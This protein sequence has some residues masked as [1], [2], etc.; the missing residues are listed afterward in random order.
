M[1]AE[2]LDVVI[3]ALQAAGCSP[4]GSSARCPAHDDHDP[5]LSFGVGDD[6]RVL[7]RCHAGCPVEAIV[8]ALELT[9]TDLF[10]PKAQADPILATYV[11]TDES[12]VPLF[13]V[14]RKSP[15]RFYQQHPDCNG[16]WCRTRGNARL[17]LY[18]LPE[19]LAG[20]AAGKTVFVCEGEKDAEAIVRTGRVA[21]T[22][23][24][25]AGKWRAEYVEM[26]A[27]AKGVVIVADRD[28]VGRAHASQVADSL[29]GRVGRVLIAEP[30]EGK[31]L[32]DHLTIGFDVEDLVTTFDSCGSA[33]PAL[34][35]QDATWP[36]LDDAALLG[37]PGQVVELLSPHSEAD[38]VALL[39]NFLAGF[40]NAAGLRPHVVADGNRNRANLDVLVIGKTAKSR[41]GTAWARVRSLLVAATATSDLAWASGRIVSGLSSGEGLINAV[42][43]EV[44]DRKGILV[45]AARDKRLLVVEE[46]FSRVLTVKGRENNPLSAIMRQAW[47]GTDLHVLTKNPLTAKAPHISIVG[48]ITLAELRAQLTE[49]DQLNGF[50]NRFLCV[51]VRRSK[52]LPNG[53]DPTQAASSRLT[54]LV[55]D[56]LGV[57]REK[58]R[59]FRNRDAE[60]RWSDLYS[61]MACDDE[62]GMVG[63]AAARA[64]AHVTRLSLVYALACGA[65]SIE[66]D[67]LEAAWALWRYCRQSLDYV[68]GSKLG[69]EVVDRLLDALRVAALGGLD[70][71]EQFAVFGRNISAGRLDA[72][73]DT[74]VRL[75][76][77]EVVPEQTG[78]RPRQVLR[79][80]A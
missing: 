30:K 72:A 55:R 11:Y 14:V 44:R 38:P 69:D 42:C 56:R 1:T 77:A 66:L 6:G 4:K 74:L 57:A 49:T 3:A 61:E 10:V 80:L 47:D 37:L 29:I 31:D 18:R 59:M 51:L 5:S 9:M 21:T 78:G 19:L 12:G 39:V 25:G 50:V 71:A 58:D 15:K 76:L 2:P 7:L 24:M 62:P 63:A 45:T 40:G 22:N 43:D 46:E 70:R 52:V 35:R 53:G 73:R 68:F 54:K 16:G 8:V 34:P 64:E 48:H 13:R 28:A 32:S 23:A 75:G 26:I 79:L 65:A 27:G 33:P 60:A 41:K 67:H 36:R 20:I 17:V